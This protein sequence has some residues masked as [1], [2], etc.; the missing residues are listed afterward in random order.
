MKIVPRNV[1]RIVA[2]RVILAWA[3]LSLVAGAATLYFELERVNRT[4][5]I[6]GAMVSVVV[7]TLIVVLAIY[8]VVKEYLM[9]GPMRPASL[10]QRPGP[11]RRTHSDGTE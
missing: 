1:G 2:T 7:L 5:Q 4:A 9:A 6:S 8:S 3:A 11:N 10:L